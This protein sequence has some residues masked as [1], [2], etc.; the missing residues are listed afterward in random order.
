M[1]EM[2]ELTSKELDAVCGAG[3]FT[4]DSFNWVHQTNNNYQFAKAYGG[5]SVFGAGGSALAANVLGA[6][7]NY[8]SIG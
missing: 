3:G 7:T 5:N 8:S 2:R 1:S 4:I 6:Q